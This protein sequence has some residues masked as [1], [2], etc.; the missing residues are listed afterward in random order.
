MKRGVAVGARSFNYEREVLRRLFEYARS[1]LRII[2]ENP[3]LEIK[4]KKVGKA[5]VVIPTKEQF[6]MLLRRC[7]QNLALRS[8]QTSWNFSATQD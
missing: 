7:V 3:A 2:L 8:P 1:T 5:E 6:R 4:K